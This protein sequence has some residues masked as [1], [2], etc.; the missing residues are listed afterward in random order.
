MRAISRRDGVP[1]KYIIRA[2]DLPDHRP[3]KDF[4]GDYVNNV[5]L[6]SE[7]FT[8]DTSEVHKLIV[9][10]IAQNEE[11]ESVIKLNEDERNGRKD[12]KA[13][14]FHYEEIGVFLKDITKADLDLRTITYTGEKK[15]TMWWMEFEKYNA[16]HT[17]HTSSM[18]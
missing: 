12:W 17:K 6:M 13:L 16:L 1:L 4:I 10:L 18:K 7:A 9:N 2:N 15:P 5:T 8:I 3:N 14:K 11:Y